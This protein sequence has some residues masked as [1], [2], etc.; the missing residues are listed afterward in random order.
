MNLKE[1]SG[2]FI[3]C[4]NEKEFHS[5]MHLESGSLTVLKLHK[6]ATVHDCELVQNRRNG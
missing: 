1:I 6:N 3:M 2:R 4:S 5:E